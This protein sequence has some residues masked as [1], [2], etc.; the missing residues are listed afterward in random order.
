[1]NNVST[2][3]IN[4]E[5]YAGTVSGKLLS[6]INKAASS[7]KGLK[8]VHINAQCNGGRVTEALKSLTPLMCD[9]GIDAKWYTL[10]PDESFYCACKALKHSLRD[11]T[12]KLNASDI[13]IYLANNEKAASTLSTM[14]VDADIWLFH[15]FQVLPMLSYMKPCHGLW[16]CHDGITELNAGVKDLLLPHMMNYRVI[17]SSLPRYFKHNRNPCE[18]VIIPPAIDPLQPRHSVLSMRKARDILSVFGI[19]P[20]RPIIGQVSC[21]SAWNNLKDS[22]DTYRLARKRVRGLQLVLAGSLTSREDRD[23]R[24]VL[25]SL[26]Q[27]IN[28]DPDIYVLTTPGIINEKEIN[29]LQ[30]GADIIIQQPAHE[31]FDLRVTEAMWKERP[32]IGGNCDGI[33]LQI[34]DGLTGFLTNDVRTGAKRITAL[35]KDHMSAAKIGSAARETVRKKYLMPRLLRD[36][37]HLFSRVVDRRD[38]VLGKSGKLLH[39]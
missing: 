24:E 31:G 28:N 10:T 6:E 9:V 4:L 35:L 11:D 13:D 18:T 29:A 30:C 16:V 2:H 15:D 7:L 14:E 37:L 8:V 5:D 22:I 17:V 3:D 27:Y 20:S 12:L 25:T 38:N 1:V 34:R 26:Q 33:R 19:D 39:V 36:Y 32:V 21:F 23:S